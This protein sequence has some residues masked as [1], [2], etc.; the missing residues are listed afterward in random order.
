MNARFRS[1]RFLYALSLFVS[2]Y[3]WLFAGWPTGGLTLSALLAQPEAHAADLTYIYT[4]LGQLKAV[5]DPATEVGLYT[6][7]PV[8]NLTGIERRSAALLSLIEFSPKCGASTV[9]LYGTAFSPT[10]SQNTVTFNGTAASV[11]AATATQ[12]VASVPGGAT[13]GPLAVTTPSGTTISSQS[14]TVGACP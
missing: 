13:T 9:T 1:S 4:D 3:V 14:F 7:D 8:G 12:L 2:F 5:V 11:T 6:Y 10:A